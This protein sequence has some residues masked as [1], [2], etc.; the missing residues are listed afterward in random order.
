MEKDKK[1]PFGYIYRVKNKVNGKRYVG[2]TISSRWKKTQ[3]PI[4][5]RWKEEIGEAIRKARRGE[6]LRNIERAIMKYGA[7]NFELKEQDIANSQQELDDKET[8]WIRELDSMNPEKGYNMKEGGLGGRLSEQ[9]KEN[10]SEIITKKYQNDPIYYNKQF[11]ERRERAKRPDW[12]KKMTEINKRKAEDPAWVEKMTL[13][14]QDRAQDNE[15]VR[16]MTKINQEN[17]RNPKIREKISEKLIDIWHNKDYQNKVSE[18]VSNSWQDALSREKYFKSKVEG[19]R[20]IQDKEQFLRDILEMKKKEINIKYDMDGKSINKRI[21]EMLGHNGLRTYSEA[22][23]YIEN[24]EIAEVL[25]EI[26]LPE[27]KSVRKDITNIDDFLNDIQKMQ[28]KDLSEKYG[29]NGSTVNRK[30]Q[31]MLGDHGVHNY[32]SAK[33]YLEDKEVKEV[34]Q[35]INERLSNQS[36]RYKGTTNIIDKDEF[37][38]DIQTMKK[39]EMTHKYDMDGKTI[40]RRIDEM[41]GAVGVKNYN[42]AK[43]YLKDKE[44]SEVLKNVK[45]SETLNYGDRTEKIDKKEFLR[46]IKN[47]Q[48]KEL[49]EKYDMDALNRRIKDMLGDLSVND[50]HEAREYLKDKD[51]DDVIKEIDK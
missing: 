26:I 19:R 27:K 50:Y 29:L 36:E 48:E 2:Q 4:E 30:L 42:E 40:N 9:A 13:L 8:N 28:K 23:K 41:L 46:D 11:R 24:K 16:K 1:R 47:M 32:T 44:I 3:I 38:K 14:N 5:E 35:D 7:N 20:E 33:S 34:V 12:I 17:A 31:E 18:G 10:L 49:R 43:E 6:R 25:E 21:E 37:L 15:W 22:K 51:I 39:Y 45:S